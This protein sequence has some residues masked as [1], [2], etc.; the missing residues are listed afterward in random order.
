VTSGED[1]FIPGLAVDRKT[2]G[3][4]AHLGLT[5]YL[6]PDATCTDGCALKVGFISSPD[7]G[8]H[9][10][11]PTQLAGPMSLGEIAN[12]SQGPMVGDYISTSFNQAGAASAL[13]AVGQPPTPAAAF[14]EAMY[15]PATPLQVATARTAVNP[16]S[17]AGVLSTGGTGT[18]LLLRSIRNN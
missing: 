8:A 11:A 13:F 5:Y 2:S 10:S 9:W 4:K 15:A 1:H 6:Y 3:S 14:D 17:S 12:T 16:S 18:G 7:A